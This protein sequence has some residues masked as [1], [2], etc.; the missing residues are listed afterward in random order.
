RQEQHCTGQSHWS[1]NRVESC[2]GWQNLER[3]SGI[4]KVSGM[5]GILM[6]DS[7][8]SES[9]PGRKRPAP[10]RV[11]QNG[12]LDAGWLPEHL[13]GAHIAHSALLLTGP[14]RVLCDIRAFC[15]KLHQY[16]D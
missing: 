8:W 1:F 16:R 4:G 7:P 9:R 12:S 3:W 11:P 10:T 6:A 2:H 13:F 14:M 5:A 15:A